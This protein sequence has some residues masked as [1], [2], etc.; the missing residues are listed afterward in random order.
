MW[1]QGVRFDVIMIAQSAHMVYVQPYGFAPAHNP[2]TVELVAPPAGLGLA[3]RLRAHRGGRCLSYRHRLEIALRSG[4]Q[5]A[6]LGRLLALPPTLKCCALAIRLSSRNEEERALCDAILLTASGDDPGP[7]GTGRNRVSSLQK[8]GLQ[9]GRHH[10][11]ISGRARQ[12]AGAALGRFF[13][14][15]RRQPDRR[16]TPVEPRRALCRGRHGCRLAEFVLV[17]LGCS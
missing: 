16:G 14:W 3:A 2:T 7:A 5:Q 11:D 15:H 12:S 8:A 4:A 13:G 9:E 10:F 6:R 17:F 1:R